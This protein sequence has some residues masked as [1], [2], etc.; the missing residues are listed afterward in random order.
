[1]PGDGSPRRVAPVISRKYQNRHKERSIA[2]VRDS[3]ICP[4]L[5]R[6]CRVIALGVPLEP[7]RDVHQRCRRNRSVIVQV[8]EVVLWYELYHC[9]MPET[10]FAHPSRPGKEQNM[11][12]PLCGADQ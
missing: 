7:P 8:V 3:M 10:I 6:T 2:G 1:M 9:S 5:C 11:L 12:Q 4:N